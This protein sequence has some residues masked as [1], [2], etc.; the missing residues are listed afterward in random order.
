MFNKDLNIKIGNVDYQIKTGNES[1]D[2]KTH[3]T[4]TEERELV[5][6][7]AEDIFIEY[8]G[9]KTFCINADFD[10]IDKA[11][12]QVAVRLIRFVTVPRSLYEYTHDTLDYSHYVHLVHQNVDNNGVYY[13]VKIIGNTLKIPRRYSIPICTGGGGRNH[14]PDG[15]AY[16]A[17]FN[18]IDESDRS[19]YE[20]TIPDE[21]LENITTLVSRH[22]VDVNAYKAGDYY[23]KFGFL[24][25]LYKKNRTP[26]VDGSEIRGIGEELFTV[27][28]NGNIGYL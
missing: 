16:V 17:D 22:M 27:D 4:I 6:P 11:G 1:F 9:D 14:L 5:R 21:G 26:N 18:D 20:F 12:Y 24:P 3:M 8:I 15:F 10:A 23:N 28:V 19:H 13:S 7:L 25:F 2:I